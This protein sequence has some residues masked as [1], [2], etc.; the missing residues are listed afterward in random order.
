MS[1]PLPTEDCYT[2]CGTLE[3]YQVLSATSGLLSLRLRGADNTRIQ[4]LADAAF[5]LEQLASAF[6][7]PEGAFGQEIE[8][9]LDLFGFPQLRAAKFPA[10]RERGKIP[11]CGAPS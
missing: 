11:A 7:S 1:R 9:C 6:D 8:L 5:T 4:V 10:V 2:V 3:S